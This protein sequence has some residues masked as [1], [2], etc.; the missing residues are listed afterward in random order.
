MI[1][2]KTIDQVY[3]ATDIVDVVS[4][5]VSLRKSGVNYKGLCPFHEEKTPS[6][7]VTPS[8]GICHC[9]GCHKGG[10]AINF[11]MQINNMTYP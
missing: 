10:N 1:D 7:V 6:F 4:D 11:L 3:Q 9:F 8:K 5:F 2:R